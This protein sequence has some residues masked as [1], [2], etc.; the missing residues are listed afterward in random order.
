[1]KRE[2]ALLKIFDYLR[3]HPCVD[4]GQTDIR[5][6]EFDHVERST[7][8]LAVTAMVGRRNWPTILSEIEKCEVRCAN[9]HRIKTVEQPRC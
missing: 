1:M 3:Q 8:R 6:L 9:C 7:K 5:V 2:D 4:C